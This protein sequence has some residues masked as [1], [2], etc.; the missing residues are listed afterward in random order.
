MFAGQTWLSLSSWNKSSTWN[1]SFSFFLQNRRK[2]WLRKEQ[3]DER[4]YFHNSQ[5]TKCLFWAEP[6]LCL[7][8]LIVTAALRG[9]PHYSHLTGEVAKLLSGSAG[10]P[11]GECDFKVMLPSPRMYKL[12]QLNRRDKIHIMQKQTKIYLLRALGNTTCELGASIA[13][14]PSFGIQWSK[15]KNKT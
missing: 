10:T 2:G 4:V 3:I 13:F 5:C 8:S 1:R 11:P 7:D 12:I 15:K 9:V 14:E 6:F